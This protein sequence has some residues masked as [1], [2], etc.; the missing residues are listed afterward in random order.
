MW[1]SLK[2]G[3]AAGRREREAHGMLGSKGLS[4]A[5]SDGRGG[6]VSCKCIKCPLSGFGVL[7]TNRLRD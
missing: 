4:M 3:S 1:V 2:G 7:K 6:E 5:K